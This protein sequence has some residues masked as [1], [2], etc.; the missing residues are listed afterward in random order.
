MESAYRIS[1]FGDEVESITHFDPLTGEVLRPARP[2]GR[3]PGDALRDGAERDRARRSGRHRRRAARAA[4]PSSRPRARCSR[5][6]GCA[7]APSTTWR[8]CA[9][10]ASA[11]ASRT[12]RATSTAATPGTPPHTLLD[13]FPDDFLIVID[14]SH[15]TVPADRRHVR[16][17]P[18][19][20]ADAGRVRLPAAVGARQPPAAVRRVPRAGATQVHVR[21]GD[22]G[23]VRA[24]P[25]DPRRRAD[26][27]ADRPGRPR[28]RGAPDA[29]PDRRP[30]RRDH[31]PASRPASGC[32]SPR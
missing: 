5:P 18:V 9:R 3:L 1:L 15:Q 14:E 11:T 13:Y 26:H 29:A 25:L 2:P 10:W 30:D 27:P 4:A 24:A 12:T 22:A 23:G 6:T 17:R 32:W 31:A 7:R 19:A 20:Q 16:G 21:V 8:C 28:G